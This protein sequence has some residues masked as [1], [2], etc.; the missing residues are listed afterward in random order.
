[1]S[2]EIFKKIILKK[3]F[4]QLPKTDIERVWKIFEKRQTS[5][6]EKIKLTRDLLRKVY[7]AFGSLKL[8]NPKIVDKKTPEEIL[9]KHISTRERFENYK[10]VYNFVV[11]DFKNKN[12]SII[13]LGC[14][15]NGFSYKFFLKKINYFGV[16]A[17]GQ[18]VDLT[19]YYFDKE[20]INGKVF[21]ESLFDLEEIKYLI[22]KIKKPKII[23]LF[24]V[25]DSLE[26]IERNYSKR[27]LREILP[28]AEKVVVSFATRSL[29][30]KKKFNVKRYWFENFVKEMNWKI[31]NDFEKG[32]ERYI[33]IK[34]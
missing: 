6:E 30:S 15:I 7:F 31:L 10:K 28:L 33:V 34:N 9:K 29:I 20:K 19:N 13:D 14:G 8:L 3:E 12:I 4:S 17:V 18:L 25:L 16:E 2:N 11:G 24:K 21:H 26:M 27:L 23:F 32:G 22:N 1:M 5:D